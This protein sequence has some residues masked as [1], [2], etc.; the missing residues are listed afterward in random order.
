MHT[1]LPTFE[2]PSSRQNFYWLLEVL[3][4]D[5]FQPHLPD[6]LRFVTSSSVITRDTKIEV[7]LLDGAQKERALPTASTC[8]SK[9]SL[10]ATPY[11]SKESMFEMLCVCAANARGFGAK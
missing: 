7:E 11:D 1:R 4:S 3:A 2:P 8:F 10:P 9:I 6:F 5:P